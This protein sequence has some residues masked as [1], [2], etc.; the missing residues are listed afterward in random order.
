MC[1][2]YI[3]SNWRAK[4]C[5]LSEKGVKRYHRYLIFINLQ[6]Q[7]A[8]R[9]PATFKLRT[10][11]HIGMENSDGYLPNIGIKEKY[12]ARA[13]S[14]YS[15]IEIIGKTLY[16]TSLI[17]GGPRLIKSFPNYKIYLYIKE[18]STET[19]IATLDKLLMIPANHLRINSSKISL[20]KLIHRPTSRGRATAKFKFKALLQHD[21]NLMTET[22]E[23][24]R[25]RKMK[26]RK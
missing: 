19:F 26:W 1:R 15:A 5:N 16:C 6:G 23:R 18:T 9:I 13:G 2:R 4:A 7:R 24:G 25:R 17:C 10:Y 20:Y 14:K 3:V 22:I 11:Y 12:I 21:S 8:K